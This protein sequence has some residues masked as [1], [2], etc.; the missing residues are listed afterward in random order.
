M[1]L[2]SLLDKDKFLDWIIG[3]QEKLRENKFV[4]YCKQTIKTLVRLFIDKITNAPDGIE[5]INR[6]FQIEDIAENIKNKKLAINTNPYLLVN[7][8]P[9]NISDITKNI[10]DYFTEAFNNFIMINRLI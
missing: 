1:A 6:I 7:L 5:K 4:I 9:D 2:I 3:R 8:L 10:N